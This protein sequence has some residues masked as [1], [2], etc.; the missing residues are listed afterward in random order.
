MSSEPRIAPPR[1]LIVEDHDGSRTG[2]T[3]L[4]RLAGCEVATAANIRDALQLLDDQTHIFL[5]LQLPDGQGADV[6]R[7]LRAR[8]GAARVALTT[9]APTDSQ[10]FLD[11]LALGPDIIF[12]KPVDPDAIIA[13]L[14]RDR[15]TTPITH[16][17]ARPMHKA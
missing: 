13:W 8:G 4:I 17:A 12:R 11:A 6:F 7:A 1:V 5:D 16:S 3:L 15:H 14:R 9:A 2:L 10:R